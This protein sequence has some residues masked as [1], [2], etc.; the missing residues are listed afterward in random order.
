MSSLDPTPGLRRLDGGRIL[1]GGSP[2]RLLKLSARGA[3]LVS[4][5]LAGRA[6]PVSPAQRQLMWR[7]VD[8][9]MVS[10]PRPQPGSIV[11]IDV[12]IPVYDDPV[13]L[14]DTL[15]G[16]VDD[17]EG[18][19]VTV[20]DDGSP[21]P[22]ELPVWAAG[23]VALIRSTTNG[24]PATAR[25]VGTTATHNEVVVFVDAGVRISPETVRALATWCAQT[26]AIVAAGP[27]I[28]SP[29]SAGSLGRYEASHSAL[30]VGRDITSPQIVGPGRRVGY[31]PTAAL[32][33]R[34]R[35]LEVVGGLDPRFRYGEDVDLIWRLDRIGSVVLDPALS[36]TH[37]ARATII[38]F[39]V[40]RFHYGASAGWLAAKHGRMMTSF[41]RRSGS[42]RRAGRVHRSTACSCRGRG[43]R[44]DRR[45]DRSEGSEVPD[46]V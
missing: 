32:A 15:G 40:Q 25:M 29:P 18:L 10:P 1:F 23:P 22:V 14:A 43:R 33:V 27:R 39:M 8:S 20:V 5:W 4:D 19:S 6:E 7:L 34:R 21:T 31:L 17:V 42:R 3:S 16:L 44:H 26:D 30:D 13:G 2:R 37:A 38:E 12:I 36:V 45:R 28:L 9:G 24:G 11:P 46:V 35:A 41:S